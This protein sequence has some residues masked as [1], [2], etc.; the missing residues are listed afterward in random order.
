MDLSL[1]DCPVCEAKHKSPVE[2][3]RR[4]GCHLLLLIKLRIESNKLAALGEEALSKL[5]YEPSTLQKES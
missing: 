5:L 4:C 3:C 2:Y 1:W